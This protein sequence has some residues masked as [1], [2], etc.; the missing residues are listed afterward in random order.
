MI[1]VSK[2]VI[3]ENHYP[4]SKHHNLSAEARKRIER[5]AVDLFEEQWRPGD[6]EDFKE[7]KNFPVER[8]VYER[9]NN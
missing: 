5:K 2:V 6:N 8:V 7:K 3:C 9:E 4:E 1:P